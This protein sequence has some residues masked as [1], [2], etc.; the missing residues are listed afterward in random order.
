[1]ASTRQHSNGLEIEV[2]AA[3]KL[4]LRYFDEMFE[5]RMEGNLELLVIFQF[6]K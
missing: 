2:K 6:G 5:V 1:M 3:N 4:M